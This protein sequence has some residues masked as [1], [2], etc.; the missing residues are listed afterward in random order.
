MR[1][2]S[3]EEIAPQHTDE[4]VLEVLWLTNILAL[5]ALAGIARLS[6]SDTTDLDAKRAEYV[7]KMAKV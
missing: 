6:E 1:W 4:E 3:Q 5:D 2:I 7:A